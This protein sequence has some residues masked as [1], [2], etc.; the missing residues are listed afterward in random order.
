MGGYDRIYP[1]EESDP[2]QVKYNEILRSVYNFEAELQIKKM[3]KEYP[4]T[5][6]VT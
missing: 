1:L 2:L 4:A 5:G 3:G 6:E